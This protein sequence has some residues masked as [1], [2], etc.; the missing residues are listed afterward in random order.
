MSRRNTG[1]RVFHRR[2]ELRPIGADGSA[3][4]VDRVS[5]GPAIIRAIAV[6]YQ[7]QPATTVFALKAELNGT[8]AETL[9]SFTGNTDIAAKPVSMTA[10]VDEAGAALA[11]TDASAGGLPVRGGLIVDVSLGDGQTSGNELIVFDVWYE[12]CEFVRTVIAPQGA[13]GSATA[14]NLVTLPG[15]DAGFVRAIAIDYVNQPAA[16]CDLT[17]KTDVAG[18]LT[19]GTTV[20]TAT[21]SATDIAPSPV[22]MAGVNETNTALAATDASDGGWPFKSN[23]YI[24]VAQGDAAQEPVTDYVAVDLWIDA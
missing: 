7:N 21:N 10:G 18:D 2:L 15:K 5:T 19:G 22:G 1:R 11:A 24:T 3:L 9:F 13:D 14:S 20:Y 6:D 8:A 16:T 4:V 17:I 23:L 12:T